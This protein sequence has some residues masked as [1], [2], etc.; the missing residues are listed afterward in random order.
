M[1]PILRL[2][3]FLVL[4]PPLGRM[5]HRLVMGSETHTP[6]PVG[7][8]ESLLEVVTYAKYSSRVG[9]A[10]SKYAPV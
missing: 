5:K 7:Q 10:M 3:N 9:G 6:R 4:A 2:L 1:P 8:K